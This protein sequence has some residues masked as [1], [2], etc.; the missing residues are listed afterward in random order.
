M[1]YLPSNN[2]ILSYSGISDMVKRLARRS[3]RILVFTVLLIGF[4]MSVS[5]SGPERENRGVLLTDRPGSVEMP[6]T[7]IPVE[8]RRDTDIPVSEFGGY[9]LEGRNGHAGHS[10]HAGHG[11]HAAGVH[12][13]HIGEQEE[14]VIH[15]TDYLYR[16]PEI[17]EAY[18]AYLRMKRESP[19]EFQVMAQTVANSVGDTR[20]FF[21][22]SIAES[23][24]GAAVYD[25]ILFELRAIGEKSEIWV[26]V[27]ELA[28]GKI[29]D[30][31]VSAMMEALEERTPPNSVNPDQGIILNNIDIFA[32]GDPSLVPDPAGTGMVK[33][34]ISNLNDGWDPDEGGGFTAG[35]FNPADLAPRTVNRNSNQAAIL[36]INSFPGIYTDDQP[37]NPNR[38]LSTVAHEFQHLIQA[39][40]GNLITFMDEGQSESAE[41]FNGF[42]AR[43]MVF[44][45]DPN[46][47][48]GNVET[49]SA[50]G[51]LRWRRGEQAVLND[52]QRA[53]LF[54]NY[55]Y[56]RVGVD[57]IGSLT[58][59]GSGNPWVQYQ[60]ILNSSGSGLD[61]RHVLAE[62]YIANWLNDPGISDGRYGYTLPQQAGVRV[63]N[64]GRRF[65]TE[66]RSWVR[67]EPVTLR[68]GGAKYTEW[69]HVQ[70][71]SVRVSS[72]SEIIHYLIVDEEGAAG[73]P[74]IIR[75][76]GNEFT[77]E[78][79]FRSAVLVSVNTVVQSV[80]SFGSR[81]FTYSAEWIP[82]ELRVVDIS[83]SVKP[84]AGFVPIPLDFSETT[85][86][87]GVAVRVDPQY[88]GELQGVDFTLW[89][90][91]ESI[92][93]TGT[94]QVILT[95]SRRS[96]GQGPDAI[97]VPNE[98]ITFREL[99]FGDLRPGMN[100]VDF[101]AD[102]IM[103]EAD[104]NYHFYLRVV[105]QSED[106]RLLFVFDQGSNDK[107]D[108]NYY[109]V[110]SI[111]GGYS[112]ATGDLSGWSRL[113]G[114]PD[115]DS[116]NDNKNLVLTTRVLSRVP[117]DEDLPELPVSDRFEMLYNYPNP[118][119][120]ETQVWFNIPA[121]VEDEV[122]VRVEVYD[123]L[124]RR[125]MTLMDENRSAGKQDVLFN[126]G[127]L[128]SGIYIL[129]MTA[130]G[131]A[132]SH[133]LML[134]K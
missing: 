111:L 66:E 80:S 124:G 125:V 132:D 89:H 76:N 63:A 121:S 101:T 7:A 90:T 64:P 65:G 49:Q 130:G 116:D 37:A 10:G 78:G 38:P 97:Y 95:D 35:F 58:Q 100:S 52:Y 46:E 103:L 33:V 98:V 128:S 59:S 23:E 75:L 11:G 105:D 50:D 36:Y 21:V 129:R 8:I 115:I 106:A 83:Y 73:P 99:D 44:L 113:L 1:H 74:E 112:P 20:N 57:A 4:A 84:T 122:R 107:S 51:F 120:S 9:P 134:L 53:Q 14:K 26:E 69:R 91:S 133:K 30:S 56:E 60:N 88:E 72:P 3:S 70:D 123:I 62:F 32:L 17:R 54:H 34:L 94:L 42:D 41:I 131:S 28:P 110:R 13:H 86:F 27:E 85:T 67:N 114:N 25:E 127:H 39:G 22:Y 79:L 6:H 93:G 119:N 16:Q 45:N 77:G 43:S 2:P 31:V 19:E 126:A 102:E 71:L 117:L 92:Q 109:P 96:S 118:F 47:V 29:D 68:Y 82:S 24:P 104:E 5:G 18:E 87:K 81:Q 40:R 15:F 48:S 108:R 12:I 61:F 55:L